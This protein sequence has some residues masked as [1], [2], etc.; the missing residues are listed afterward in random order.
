MEGTLIDFVSGVLSPIGPNRN[1]VLA[2]KQDDREGNRLKS[3]FWPA[4]SAR[5]PL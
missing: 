5:R 2:L 3:E 1:D 4:G